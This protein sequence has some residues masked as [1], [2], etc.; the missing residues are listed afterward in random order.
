MDNSDTYELEE[1]SVAIIG[2][3]GRFPG[4]KNID[5]FWHNLKNGVESITF[6]SDQELLSSGLDPAVLADTNYVKA[7]GILDN[8][9]EFDAAFFDFNPKEAEI[10][11]PQQRLF[12]EC[13]WEALENAGYDPKTYSGAIGVYG[14]V[15][16]NSYLLENLNANPE[17]RKTVGGYQI[18]TGNDKDFLCTRVSYKLNLSGPSVTVQTACSTSLVAVV[19][20]CKSLLDYQCDMVLAGG[21]SISLPIKSGYLYQEGMI[22][23]PDGHCRAFDAKAQGTVGGN[24]V[25]I[26]VLKRLE[27]ALNDGDTIHAVIKGAA[28]N[29]DGAL[30]IGYTAPSVDAQ[31]RVI[32]EALALADISPETISYVEAHGTATPLGDPVEIAALKQAYQA[33]TDKQGYCAIGS[34][35]TNIGHLD[36]AAGVAGLIKTVLALK[37]Q[38]LPPSLHFETPNPKL[39]L[40][41]SPFY[42]NAKLSEWETN[43]FPR[44]AGVSSFG[45][46]GTNAH[47]VLEEAPKPASETEK[48][49]TNRPWQLLLLSAKTDTAL[50]TAT[51]QLLEHLKQ[52]PDLNLADVAYTYQVGRQVFDHCRML[53]CQTL[54]DAVTALETRYTKPMLSHTV[55]NDEEPSMVFMFS[56]QGT[57]YVNM[58]LELYQT[59]SVFR[60]YV[61][62]CAEFLKPHLG[63]DLRTVLYPTVQIPPLG[64]GGEQNIEFSPDLKQTAIA[65]PALF[66]IEYALA[67]L[68]M[69]WGVQPK[70][71]IG[72]SI[73]EYVAACL[74]GVFTLEEALMLVAARG[75][76]MQSVAP[77]AMLAVPLSEQDIRP[78]LNQN[79]NLSAINVPVQCV[80]SGTI[81]AVAQFA[82]QLAEQGIECQRLHTSHAFHSEMMSPILERFLGHVQKIP[83]KLPKI[84]FLSN[85]TGTW[86]SATDATSPHYWAIHLRQTVR[87]AAGLQHLLKVPHHILLEIGPGRTLSTFAKRHSD[88][89]GQLVLTSLR[90][91]K[92]EQSD[93]AFLLNTLG[94]LWM[95]NI[96]I[97]WSRFYAKEH[98]LRLS[99]PTYPFERQRYWVDPQKQASQEDQLQQFWHSVVAAGQKQAQQGISKLD[100][101]SYLA[102]KACLDSLCVAYMGKALKDL[103][104]FNGPSEKSSL[105]EL[106]EQFKIQPRYQQLLSRWVQVLVEQGQLQ[107][108]GESFTNLPFLTANAFQALVE[109]TQVKWADEPHWLERVQYYGDNLTAV[110]TGELQALELFSQESLSTTTG[111]NSIVQESPVMQYYNMIARATMQQVVTLLPPLVKLNILEIGG[112]TGYTTSAIMPILPLKQTQYTFTDISRLLVD[113]AKQKFSEYPFIQY[114]SLDI[115][116]SPQ[117]QGYERH[118]FDMVIAINVLHVTRNIEETLTHV[119]SLLAPSGLLLI[120][121]ITQ[122]QLYFDITD[123]L[124]MSRL[125]DGQRNQGNPFLSKEQWCQALLAQGFVDVVALPETDVIGH[126]IL[127]AQADSSGKQTASYAFTQLLE[128]TETVKTPQ[129]SLSKKPDIADWFY[130][131][132]W[133]RSLLPK[134]FKA[135]SQA[136]PQ[137]CWLVFLDEYGLGSQLVKRLEPEGQEIITVSV[138]QA[139]TAHSEHVYTLNP[140]QREDYEALLKALGTVNKFPKT[141]IHLWNVTAN[142]HDTS[143]L[144]PVDKALNLGFYS[145]FFLAQ[146]LSKQNVT[147]ELQIVVVSNGIQAVTGEEALHPEKAT[148]L[149]PVK[150][151]GQEY[152]NI[153]C[154]S[155]DVVLPPS[156]TGNQHKFIEQLLAEL[157]NPSEDKV[158]AYRGKHRWVQSFES[159]RLNKPTDETLRLR[160]GGVYL[161]TGGLGNIGLILAEY[162]AKTVQAKLILVG[163]STFPTEWDDWLNCHDEHDVISRKI[164]KLQAI[165]AQ[166]A[167]VLV[168]ST[169]VANLQKMQEVVTIAE[170]R[171]GQINGVIHGAGVT[172]IKSFFTIEK[173]GKT[174]CEQQFQPKV[175]GTLVLNKVLQ[176]KKL[177]FCLLLSSLSSILGGVGFIAYSAANIFMDVFAQQCNQTSLVPWI[178]VNWDGWPSDTTDGLSLG[179]TLFELVMTPEEGFNAFQRILSAGRQIEQLVVSTGD[180]QLRFKQWM[181]LDSGIEPDNYQKEASSSRHSRPALPTP[182]L[183]P[184]NPIE[185]KLANIWQQFLGIEAVGIHDDFFELGGDSLIAVQLIAKLRKTFPMELSAQILLNAPTIAS[186]AQLI[187]EQLIEEKKP[188]LSTQ[189]TQPALPS[190]LVEIQAG[191]RLKAPLFLVHPVGG[192]VYIY[193]DLAY[194]LGAEQPIY[195]IQAQGLDGETEPLDQIEEMA[196]QYIE[197]LR[198]R[199]PD[200]P[201]LLGGASSGGTVAFEMAQQLHALDQQVA[202]LTMID[203]PGPNQT[204]VELETDVEI[205]AYLL[206]IGANISVSLDELKQLEPDEQLHYFMEQAKNS[207]NT[208]RIL[209][210]DLEITQLR[211]FLHIFKVNAHAIQCY[212]PQKVYS[213]QKII[214]FRAKERDAFNPQHPEHGWVDLA[215]GGLEVI[216]VPGNHFTM[217]YPPHVEVMAKIL[218]AYLEKV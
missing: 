216:E 26:V 58:G 164:R 54:E 73:G 107:Q 59:E 175:H 110:L 15:S 45:I 122:P 119:R 6:F 44:R 34:A 120:W 39:D 77:G 207:A 52:H 176:D 108:E 127:V 210:T 142:N 1:E 161:I 90:H 16:R 12:L 84:P 46:G 72:H 100:N 166:G 79:L 186:L 68:W 128:Q 158:I 69:A 192:H 76:L 203:T 196:T 9:A 20:G 35:K 160:K 136:F 198:I 169:D 97:N 63:F 123:A 19:M 112:G 4:A 60:E 40:A 92:E 25:G 13:A 187:E 193:R 87:F 134:H 209:P 215:A 41:N 180:L 199:Q 170:E 181:K 157:T 213:D 91:P 191:N 27:D 194:H 171:F 149:G 162:L 155:I 85:V 104:A 188:K 151:I 208:N 168:A 88:N 179:T 150:T 103:G 125:E 201:Y 32:V 109:E 23:S 75:R 65:Q 21:V 83:L 48:P 96:A 14:G 102:K 185:Q 148:I 101:P 55:E 64:K 51:T 154:R 217:N 211:H 200:G 141:I 189:L 173:T 182:Y 137:Q 139:F 57:Q 74:A 218:K 29:N 38:L 24:G 138:G 135:E 113:L 93:S 214:F 49:K 115:E 130:L 143:A 7:K 86:M 212:K 28:I 118:S 36:A 114:Q 144:V 153:N 5:E 98:R 190:S 121:E 147:D 197:M 47:V 56:G 131:P 140:A 43:A 80:V 2:L 132:S 184:R 202:L 124:L 70:A 94:Q 18:L 111:E 133:K 30:K 165:E 146:A 89:A 81:E 167:E 116:Q 67:Q 66:V 11:D 126:H 195:G 8:V 177:D 17:L 61:D 78:F 129:V 22:A 178:S 50:E 37:H 174:H 33:K 163:R 71:M 99:V 42:V 204:I 53:V 106:F 183:A 82:A 105:D 3:S 159:V 206:Q 95:A 145:L 31:A 62:R 156:T 152:P 172:E 117:E 10:I 205:L